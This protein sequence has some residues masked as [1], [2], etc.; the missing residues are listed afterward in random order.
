MCRRVRPLSR[1]SGFMKDDTDTDGWSI[2]RC[3]TPARLA[4]ISMPRSRN[5]PAGPMP[6]R[7]RCAG[8]WMAP[9]DRITSLPEFGLLALDQRHHADAAGA[10]EQQLGDLRLGRDRQVRAPPCAGVEI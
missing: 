8:E 4:R 7:S 5:A 9:E 10:L 1:A 2:S 6:A 3:P